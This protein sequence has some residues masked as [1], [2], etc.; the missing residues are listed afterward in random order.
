M[1]TL[2]ILDAARLDA[3][4]TAPPTDLLKEVVAATQ[5]LYAAT[6]AAAPWLSYLAERDGTPVG[7]CS[8]K[9]P[10]HE[11]LVE[12][13]YF[14]FPENEGQGIAKQ[15]AVALLRI[16]FASSTIKAVLAHTLPEENASTRV[17]RHAGFR[18]MGQVDDPD[19]GSV[20]RWGQIREGYRPS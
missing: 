1:I 9:G 18:L 17:L 11:G 10:P 6:G 15:M 16:A 3:L 12:I 14:T 13:A 19:D 8:F 5:A 7:I 20:W 4:I 2:A